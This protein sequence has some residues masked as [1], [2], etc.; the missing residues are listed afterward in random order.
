MVVTL[1]IG[2]VLWLNVDPR[3]QLFDE[4]EPTPTAILADVTP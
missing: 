3:H 4:V 2:A 1:S